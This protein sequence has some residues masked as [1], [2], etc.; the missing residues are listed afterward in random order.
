M[1]AIFEAAPVPPL[2]RRTP[3][4]DVPLTI[5]PLP[6]LATVCEQTAPGG[7]FGPWRDVVLDEAA[8]GLV[9]GFVE[10]V[11]PRIAR[12]LTAP[13]EWAAS[14]AAYS[15]AYDAS[16]DRVLIERRDGR[17]FR[18]R[19]DETDEGETAV[20]A[21]LG[22][23]V[24]DAAE[25]G[26]A[27]RAVDGVT[28]VQR[29]VAPEPCAILW[30]PGCGLTAETADTRAFVSHVT[31]FAGRT[32]ID[33]ATVAELR[34]TLVFEPV[35]PARAWVGVGDVFNRVRAP[36]AAAGEAANSLAT[37]YATALDGAPWRFYDNRAVVT[38]SF[39]VGAIDGSGGV[40][41]LTPPPG[42]AASD[43]PLLVGADLWVHS[44]AGLG[45]RRKI[46]AAAAT[47]PGIVTVTVATPFDAAARPAAESVCAVL[48]PMFVG[49]PDAA[50]AAAFAPEPLNTATPLFRVRIGL[51]G[52]LAATAGGGP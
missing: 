28:T 51:V 31:G 5:P 20:A 32:Q 15:V 8:S 42:W 48:W 12:A 39:T 43:A 27:G 4:F 37:L 11:A 33:H 3:F 35:A 36:A 29:L 21:I 50:T 2:S 1:P 7:A 24:G 19:F 41:T 34:R 47:D 44:G 16:L 52:A 10:G 49:S 18:L 14:G 40:L 17:A 23:R 45:Q 22:F 30:N 13:D 38:G 46:V 26:P 6:R 25:S 9:A